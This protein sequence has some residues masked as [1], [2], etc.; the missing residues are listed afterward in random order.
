MNLQDGEFLVA[1]IE[2]NMGKME[3]ELFAKETPLTVKNFV[4][5]A[6]QGYYDGV[7]FHRIIDDFMIQGGDPT[8]TGMGGKSIYGGPFKDELTKN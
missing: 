1:I 7:T 3:L 2:T 6:L 8:G 5:L 4:G